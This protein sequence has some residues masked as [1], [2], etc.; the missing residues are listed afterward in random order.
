MQQSDIPGEGPEQNTGHRPPTEIIKKNPRTGPSQG[1]PKKGK[2]SYLKGDKAGGR[3]FDTGIVGLSKGKIFTFLALAVLISLTLSLL[4]FTLKRDGNTLLVNQMILEESVSAVVTTQETDTGRIDNIIANYATKVDLEAL[5]TPSLYWYLEE[6]L[7]GYRLYAMA[8]R[9]GTYV[10]EVTLIY[11]TPYSL[12][13][14]NLSNAYKYFSGNW[15][16]RDFIPE[17]VWDESTWKVKS[18]SFYTS[19]FQLEAGTEWDSSVGT[20]SATNSYV[21]SAEVMP[22]V[23]PSSGG[24]GGGGI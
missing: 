15:T 7:E 11:P 21:I 22:A 17:F 4:I 18:A 5:F 16:G 9:T 8:S 24:G 12:G 6:E 3:G 20:F 13:T 1:A 14:S 2:L 19:S 10:A 23:V